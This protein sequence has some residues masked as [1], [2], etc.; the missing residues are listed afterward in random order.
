MSAGA[1][2]PE[3]SIDP[4]ANGPLLP[5]ETHDV[6]TEDVAIPTAGESVRARLDMPAGVAH[7][8]AM[9]AVHGIHHLGMDEP[10]LVSF[11]RAVAAQDDELEEEGNQSSSA[12][13][14][15]AARTVVHNPRLSPTAD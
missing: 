12:R 11:A 14:M 5:V 3:R 15:A 2:R 7:P 9:V 6:T 13:R 8:G 10:G 4:H 1:P